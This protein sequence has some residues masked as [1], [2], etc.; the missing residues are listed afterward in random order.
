MSSNTKAIENPSY[1]EVCEGTTGHVEVAQILFD[2]TKTSFKEIV[3]FF[4]TFHDSTT[5]ERQGGDTGSQYSSVIF[6]HSIEQHEIATQV[7]NELQD[8]INGGAE[9]KFENDTVET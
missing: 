4:F 2:S 7:K 6:C 1:E 8:L 9:H 5:F 3:K